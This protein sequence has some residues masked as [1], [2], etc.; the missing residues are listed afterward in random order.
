[1]LLN[2]EEEASEKPSHEIAPLPL[3]I[4]EWSAIAEEEEL[5]NGGK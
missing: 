5:Q 4:I 2:V 1:M 3:G